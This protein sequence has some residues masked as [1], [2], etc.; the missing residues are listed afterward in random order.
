M[1]NNGRPIRTRQRQSVDGFA[2]PGVHRNPPPPASKP[3]PALVPT[4]LSTPGLSLANRSGERELPHEV[5]DDKSL[6]RDRRRRVGRN[7]IPKKKIKKKWSRRKKTW[8]VVLFIFLAFFGVG[9]YYG[10]R[11][12]GNIDKV[13]H[14]NIFSD[15]RALF[16]STTLKGQNTGR[17]NILLAGDSSDDPGHSGG[18]LTDS[19]LIASI[20]TQDHSVFLLSIPR[21]LW[22][23][24]P[25]LNSYQKINAANDV[26][27]FNQPGYPSGGMGQLQEI[28]Q[29]DLGIP[30]DYYALMDYGAFKDSVNAVGGVTINVQSSD[31]R[32]LYDCS[33][34]YSNHQKLVDLSNG[35]HTLN[36]E[37][38]LDLARARGDCPGSYGFADSDFQRTQDQRE[39]FIAIAEK[40]KSLGIITNPAKVSDL[41][42]AFG[43]NVQT[44]LSLPDLLA[45]IS[46]TKGT[47][48]ANAK[49]YSFSST[50]TGSANPILTD[51]RSPSGEDAIIP[52]AGIGNFAALTQYYE[53]LTSNNPVVKEGANVVIL[54]GSDVIGL[55]SKQEA[56]LEGK[57]FSVAAIADATS[58]YPG[59]MIVDNSKG[60]DPNSLKLLKQL[61]PGT[62]VTTDTTPTEATEAQGYNANFVVILGKN[63][64]P[65]TQ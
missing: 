45:L 60:A 52:T 44:D 64:D 34:D 40:A 17:I 53:K 65:T 61:Y 2:L 38:A 14:G 54:N 30:I 48:P 16:S 58:E 57:G 25:G 10:S 36:G 8:I 59:T 63:W 41:F 6:R 49:S 23:Y 26:S 28:I 18:V 51:Y 7:E 24:V 42:N 47:N 37:Q 19:I 1:D 62:V 29:T 13:F 56:I 27:N 32:G 4:T 5:K 39:M 3:F 12:V 43:N 46:I 33:I 50:L 21:D 31:P 11:I 22:V 9:G 20:D 55:A 15:A 35:I